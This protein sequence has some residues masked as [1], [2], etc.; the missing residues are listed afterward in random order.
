[1]EMSHRLDILRSGLKREHTGSHNFSNEGGLEVL[2]CSLAEE[3]IDVCYFEFLNFTS[4]QFFGW[5][6]T[7]P[8]FSPR[9]CGAA[10]P[11]AKTRGGAWEWLL[12]QSLCSTCPATCYLQGLAMKQYRPMRAQKPLFQFPRKQ[13]LWCRT[14]CPNSEPGAAGGHLVELK[15][16]K[17]TQHL[18]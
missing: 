5:G 15:M 7:H 9:V 11:T 17:P 4:T 13:T 10:N 1:M 14:W 12:T 3:L 8:P 6:Y 18:S 2:V 16:G